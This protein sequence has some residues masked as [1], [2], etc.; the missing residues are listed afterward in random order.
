MW[1]VLA[2][3]AEWEVLFWASVVLN[4]KVGSI[5]CFMEAVRWVTV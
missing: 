1:M 5:F 4:V 3:K 2:E